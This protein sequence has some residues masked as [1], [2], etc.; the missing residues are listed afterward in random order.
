MAEEE[1]T[2]RVVE[3]GVRYRGPLNN[4]EEHTVEVDSGKYT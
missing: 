3:L 4:A 1:A 2:I